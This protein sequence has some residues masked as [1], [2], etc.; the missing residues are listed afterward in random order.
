MRQIKSDTEN[1]IMKLLDKLKV[2]Y[3]KL[4]SWYSNKNNM[5]YWVRSHGLVQGWPTLWAEAKNWLKLPRRAKQYPSVQ[6]FLSYTYI[7]HIERVGRAILEVSMGQKWPAGPKLDTPGLVQ[8][9]YTWGTL[10]PGGRWE[11]NRAGNWNSF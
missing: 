3:L 7:P 8:Q 9:F 1:A 10:T 4:L 6:F 11:A 5:K 2:C